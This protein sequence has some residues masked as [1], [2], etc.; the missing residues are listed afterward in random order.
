[1]LFTTAPKLRQHNKNKIDL[2]FLKCVHITF[3]SFVLIKPFSILPPTHMEST[4]N[5]IIQFY[6]SFHFIAL[7]TDRV[8]TN[9]VYQEIEC[10]N[11]IMNFWVE[12][13]DM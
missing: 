10:D 1:M 3:Y 13:S 2:K 12:R 5:I 11:R 8:M 4:N 6:F 9:S 7:G